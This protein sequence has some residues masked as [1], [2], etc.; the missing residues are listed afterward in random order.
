MDTK[1]DGYWAD[2][3]QAIKIR[4]GLFLF[5]LIVGCLVYL[6]G[7][8]VDFVT[9]TYISVLLLLI[10]IVIRTLPRFGFL[11]VLFITISSFIV[12]RYFSWRINYT[13]VP[14]DYLSY[15]GSL[16][17]FLAELYGGLMFFL[18]LFVNIRPIRRKSIPLPLDQTL[19]PTVDVIIPSYNESFDLVKITLAAARNIDYPQEKIKIY[20]LDDGGTTEKINNTSPTVR[21]SALARSLELKQCCAEL[22]ITYLTRDQNVNAKAG[23]MNN[24][25][26]YING[27]L[28]LVLDA[29]HMPSMDILEKIVGAFIQ[30][31][32]VCLVQTPHFFINPDP[33]EK[34]LDLFYSMPAES[35]MF[36]KTVQMGLDFWQASFFCG[37]AAVLRRK[38][39]DEIG[40]FSGKTITED[41]E[42]TLKLH[43]KGWR[44]HYLFYPLISGLQPETFDSFMIQRMR[45]AQGMVQ[46]F[47]FNNPLVMPNLT[48]SQRICY[49]SS[50]IFWFFPIARVIFLIAPGLYLFFGLKIYHANLQEFLNYTVPFLGVLL[51][52]N[53]YLFRD[54]RWV[55]VSEIYETMQ[56]LFSFRA[57]LSVLRNPSKPKF[58]VTP[59]MEML[60]QDVISPLSQPFYWAL[61]YTLFAIS[62]AIWRFMAY[63]NERYIIVFTSFWAFYNLLLLL[64]TLGTL[65]ERQQ[66]RVNPRM[67]VQIAATWLTKST[68]N[69]DEKRLPMVINDLSMGGGNLLSKVELTNQQENELTYIEVQDVVNK[70][71]ICYQASIASRT[72]KNDDFIYGVKFH[73]ANIDEYLPIVKLVHGDSSRWVNIYEGTGNNPGLISSIIFMINT[74]VYHG[75]N[76]LYVVL[77]NL[78]NQLKNAYV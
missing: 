3:Y 13:L 22:D 57:V 52:T 15:I 41:S 31:E 58:A 78:F 21:E 49:L 26:Q 27:D 32:K 7:L 2:L 47:I 14:E 54:V 73:F 67:P 33:F 48:V 12:L 30:D 42:T 23:N 68:V 51:L 55:F 77:K 74:G 5:I 11:H 50:M 29:D 56:S 34:N 72:K 16:T 44:S 38:A 71:L 64:A 45:W 25:L 18:S 20:L 4:Y 8:R 60:H 59:K 37:S 43:S 75:L 65:H 9:Q 69:S 10:L 17:L 61:G 1:N 76:H 66:R 70:T 36:Y 53:H 63:P 40:G 6:S 24:A 35:D 19:W 28:I 62:A 46:N 39:I